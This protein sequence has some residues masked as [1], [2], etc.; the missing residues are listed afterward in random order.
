[1][2][3]NILHNEFDIL[4]KKYGDINL[5]SIYGAG[6]IKN[7]DIMFIF[8]N[9]TG[10]NISSQKDWKGIKAPWLGTKQV[11][12]M[13][14][15]LNYISDNTYLSI[16]NRKPNEWNIEFTHNLYT[17]IAN[18]RIYLTNL[19]KCTQIDARPLSNTVF[20]EYLELMYREIDSICPKYIISFGNQVSSI[21]LKKN[22]SV[23]KYSIEEYEE[24]KIDNRKYLV[25][26]TYYPVGQGRRNMGKAIERIKLITTL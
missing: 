4:Q 20:K 19:A 1:M 14:N 17:E 12:D 25:Y 24:L 6:C 13:F 9:P 15:S 2:Q 23:S 8:M 5:D 18:N 26:P 10:R 3:L 11:W 16:K 21:L 22:I 7:P